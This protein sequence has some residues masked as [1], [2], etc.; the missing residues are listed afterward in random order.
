MSEYPYNDEEYVEDEDLYSEDKL[1][2]GTT[3]EEVESTVKTVEKL[4]IP[5]DI[6]DEESLA[7]SFTLE[8]DDGFEIVDD[9]EDDVSDTVAPEERLRYFADKIMS[10]LVGE[11][12]ITQYARD[13]LLSITNPR[14][15]R[16][17]NHILFTVLY[18]YRS[19]LRVIKIDEE[20]I[21]LYLT[22]NRNVLKKSR[23]FIDINAYGE[24]DG[25]EELG[26][27][28]GVCKHFRRLCGFEDLTIEDF[29][30]CFDKYLIE[31][32]AIEALKV[33]HQAEQ[34][35]NDGLR[36][37]NREYIGFEDSN[38][39]TKKRMAE[40]E[41]LVDFSMG[42][43]FV[44]MSEVLMGEKEDGKKP[45]KIGDFGRLEPLNK[46]YGGIYTGMFYQII[47][48]PKGGKTKLCARLCHNISVVAGNNVTVWAQEGGKDAWAA[49][50]RAIHFDYT[51]N[52]G[53]E[54]IR[55]R[56]Y[57]VTQD[58]ILKDKFPSDTL[59]ELEASSK[60]DLATNEE[61][62]SVD[63]IDRPFVIETFIEDIDTSV[64]ENN[65]KIVIIDYLQLI[66]STTN[67]PERERVAESYK[68]LLN[69]CK[70]NNVAVLT[71]GQYKQEALNAMLSKS[72][73]SGADMRTA[74][75]GSSEVERTPDVIFALWASATDIQNNKMTILAVPSRMSVMYPPVDVLVDLGTCQFISRE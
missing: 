65:S 40:I 4:E 74:G 45:Y 60:I 15:F 55:Q 24:V 42:A 49:Q 8:V 41:G 17:E 34:I 54:D 52:T 38:S 27:I 10:C 39:F 47:A 75:G 61:Y 12:P 71:P 16:D 22:R 51:Y 69:Y 31:F 32:K 46:A 5:D 63:F 43:G 26:Y 58:V 1:G 50:M 35:L 37:G 18:N 62:G 44:K 72:D 19:R 28:A 29:E 48:P 7:K 14:L 9:D 36:I 64:K 21:R 66:G 73:V 30:T 33:Y 20:F 13:K 68:K 59:R 11:K 56:K 67:M 2:V 25:S 23:A 70:D 57:G 53:V 6:E 3:K